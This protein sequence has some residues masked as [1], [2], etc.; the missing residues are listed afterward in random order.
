MIEFICLFGG[1]Y[2]FLGGV[3][4]KLENTGPASLWQ[5]PVVTHAQLPPQLPPMIPHMPAPQC[6]P[7]GYMPAHFM[8]LGINLVDF[9]RRLPVIICA[10]CVIFSE[11]TSRGYCIILSRVEM[12]WDKHGHLKYSHVSCFIP[13]G[14]MIWLAIQFVTRSWWVHK[15]TS[16][17]MIRNASRQQFD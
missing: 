15:F 16:W 8:S 3:P 10:G 4:F 7:T 9:Q 13:N 12:G 11:K 2:F 6:A 14:C 17:F 1:I 5:A